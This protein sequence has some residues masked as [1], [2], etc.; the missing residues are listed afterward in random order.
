MITGSRPQVN[1]E[2]RY[3]ATDT[4]KI[5]GIHRHTLER[6]TKKGAIL[7]IIHIDSNRFYYTGEEILRFWNTIA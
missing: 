2:D 7:P 1:K 5:L 4:C 3:S 6:Y